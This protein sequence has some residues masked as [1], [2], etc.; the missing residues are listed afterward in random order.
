MKCDRLRSLPLELHLSCDRSSVNF[1]EEC[2]YWFLVPSGAGTSKQF[3][4]FVHSQIFTSMAATP[5]PEAHY[6]NV[7][8]YNLPLSH[9]HHGI[10]V[11]TH[12]DSPPSPKH[13]TNH[14]PRD[15]SRVETQLHAHTSISLSDALSVY[16]IMRRTTI[17]HLIV[18]SFVFSLLMSLSLPCLSRWLPNEAVLFLFIVGTP[19]F[20]HTAL[21]IAPMKI[22]R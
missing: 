8:L 2:G 14:G 22:E 11:N 7:S 1:M 4:L 17:F 12:R 5:I 15:S 9:I 16:Q 6:S 18:K 21:L 3:C 20:S 19:V 13:T 10:I